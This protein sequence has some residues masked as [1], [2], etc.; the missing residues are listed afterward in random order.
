MTPRHEQRLAQF[1]AYIEERLDDP[2]FEL[3]DV[4]RA[5]RLTERCVRRIFQCTNETLSAFVLRRRLERAARLLLDERRTGDTILSIALDC[6]FND[7][8]CFSRQ[9]H[10]HFGTTARSYRK[11]AGAKALPATP[12]RGCAL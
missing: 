12:A 10:R 8:A 2:D 1:R 11:T 6:G 5:F 3:A 7:A 4:A 9:F